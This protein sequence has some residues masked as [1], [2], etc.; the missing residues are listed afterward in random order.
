[1]VF[2]SKLKGKLILETTQNITNLK[3]KQNISNNLLSKAVLIL[4]HT[5]KGFP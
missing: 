2:H 5:K 3:C 1:M 4:K